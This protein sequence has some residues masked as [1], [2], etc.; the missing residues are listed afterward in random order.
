[1]NSSSRA[2]LYHGEPYRATTFRVTS[3]Q[4]QEDAYQEHV[5][6]QASAVGIVEGQKESIDLIP[7]LGRIPQNRSELMGWV[8]EDTVI[9]VYLF[10]TLQ[11]QNR[12]QPVL[13]VPTAEG[14]HERELGDKLRTSTARNHGCSHLSADPCSPL[15]LG[16][17]AS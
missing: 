12:I 2:Q 5:Y 17:P 10:P 7:Y 15:A 8:P 16:I 11:G 14:Y 4:Y 9:P 3:V 1:M 6:T 13:A